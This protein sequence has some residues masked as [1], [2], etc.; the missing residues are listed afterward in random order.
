MSFIVRLEVP[1]TNYYCDG[2]FWKKFY[3]ECEKH[4]PSKEEVIN[5]ITKIHEENLQYPEYCGDEKEVID[6]LSM[7]PE[8]EWMYVGNRY[9]GRNTFVEHPKFGK[10][11]VNWDIIDVIKVNS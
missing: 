5:V 6:I 4:S 8:D 2:V 7:I 9:V 1:I 10:Q 3:F 11:T